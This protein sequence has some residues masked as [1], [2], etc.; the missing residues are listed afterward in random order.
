MTRHPASG[1]GDAV[2]VSRIRRRRDQ[3]LSSGE[4][5][6]LARRRAE[7]VTVTLRSSRAAGRTAVS[8]VDDRWGVVTAF[9]VS[10]DEAQA[11]FEDPLGHAVRRGLRV[12]E[13]YRH[14]VPWSG[15]QAA[16]AELA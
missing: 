12:P 13:P 5:Q 3:P 11:A 9:D 16:L 15:D 7:G 8:L 6:V 1:E 4:W 10:G 2:I 14:G